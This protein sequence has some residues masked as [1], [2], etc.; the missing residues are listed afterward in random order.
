M[1]PEFIYLVAQSRPF[2]PVVFPFWQPF[3]VQVPKGQSFIS[4]SFGQVSIWFVF[5]WGN[6]LSVGVP[7]IFEGKPKGTT[8]QHSHSSH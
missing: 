4:R 5:F 6:Q 1:P 7:N 8:K 3:V 2:D